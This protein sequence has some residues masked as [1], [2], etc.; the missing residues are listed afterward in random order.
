VDNNTTNDQ[1]VWVCN[2]GAAY[3]HTLTYDL[4]ADTAVAEFALWSQN[5]GA[6]QA[7]APKDWLIQSGPTSS[8]PWTTERTV[9]AQT[10]WTA[11]SVRTF[12]V[13]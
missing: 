13:P 12:S 11:G 7:R 9:T 4:G 2:T 1:Q 6:L 5:D 10:G 3:P 8:G